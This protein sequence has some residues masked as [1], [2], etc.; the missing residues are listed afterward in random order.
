MFDVLCST[1]VKST[2]LL[3]NMK[4]AS[5]PIADSVIMFCFLCFHD[6]VLFVGILVHVLFEHLSVL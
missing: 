1:R 6:S 4:K 3:I 5:I 2:V